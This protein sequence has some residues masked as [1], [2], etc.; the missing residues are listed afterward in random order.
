MARNHRTSNACRQNSLVPVSRSELTK[1][2]ILTATEVKAAASRLILDLL[3]GK[4]SPQKV[5]AACRALEIVVN[6][7]SMEYSICGDGSL[8]GGPKQLTE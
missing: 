6:V 8:M 2:G 1:S 7:V 5:T 3:A 4:I